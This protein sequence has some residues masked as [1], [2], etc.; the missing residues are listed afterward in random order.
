MPYSL[1]LDDTEQDIDTLVNNVTNFYFW[2][3]SRLLTLDR[4]YAKEILNS[5]GAVQA[6]TDKD[7]A[8]IALSYHC[9]SLMD[10]YWVKDKKETVSFHDI[11]LFE[12]CRKAV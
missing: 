3:A 1:Y 11:N 7:R 5:I 2:C 6:M 12:E 9:L 8:L 10:I 4:Q